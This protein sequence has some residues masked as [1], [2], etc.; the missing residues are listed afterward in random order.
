MNWFELAM[1][2]LGCMKAGELLGLLLD[3]ALNL[4]PARREKHQ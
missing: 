1:Y 3:K 4:V 2:F